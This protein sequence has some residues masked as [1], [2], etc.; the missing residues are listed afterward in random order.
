MS[1]IDLG[2]WEIWASGM[3]LWDKEVNMKN[4][5]R[6][7]SC[8]DMVFTKQRSVGN[9]VM[10][11]YN[12]DEW[13]MMTLFIETFWPSGLWYR[14]N[15]MECVLISLV[16]ICLN[17]RQADYMVYEIK[18]AMIIFSVCLFET[19]I[20]RPSTSQYMQCHPK[21]ELIARQVI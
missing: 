19:Y 3:T 20:K 17:V 13:K 6:E 9:F 1:Y 16:L 8:E 4:M 5:E 21:F 14:S 12:H 18:W 10:V 15:W 11:W 2:F 7:I